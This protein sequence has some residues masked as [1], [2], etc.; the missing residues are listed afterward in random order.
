MNGT[1]ESN[2]NLINLS[3]LSG[4]EIGVV[5]GSTY[6]FN[7]FSVTYGRELQLTKSFNL[8]G[9]AGIGS[10]HQNSKNSYVVAGNTVSFPLKLNIKFYF[11]KKFGLGINNIYSINK[12]NNNLSTNLIA[13]YNF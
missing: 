2:K 10:Y 1:L 9:F 11:N 7:E 12:L 6:N 3:F 13:H 5:G 8:E 4:S